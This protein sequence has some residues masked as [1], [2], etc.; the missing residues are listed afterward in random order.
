MINGNR[1]LGAGRLLLALVL[2]APSAIADEAPVLWY[3]PSGPAA[4]GTTACPSATAGWAP[5]SS[6]ASRRE[7]L[8]LN[9]RLALDGRAAR[10]RQPRGPGAP[11]RGAP[12]A[13]RGPAP[14][15]RPRWPSA[16]SWAGRTASSPTR[17]WAT[18]AW[19]SSTRATPSDYRLELDLDTAIA[20]VRYRV[21]GVRYT[22]EVFA[23]APDQ[24]LVVRL[25]AD[26]PGAGLALGLASTA[27]RTRAPQVVGADRLDL[28]GGLAGE[29]GPALPGV[30][31]DRG[32]G[33]AP[34]AVPGA[35][36]GGGAPTR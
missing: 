33:R 11:A 2:V 10:A 23:S 14:A 22:R 26:Q 6:A 3:Q 25:T 12:A 21:G 7:R 8:Q 28:V 29:H 13:L 15:R 19:P 34:R 24:V 4:S 17:R 32:R 9:E 35:H 16:S 18:C 20:R 31:E 36:R 1:A 5:W 27:R 30:G